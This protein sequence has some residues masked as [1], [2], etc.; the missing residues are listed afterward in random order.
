MP[1][2]NRATKLSLPASSSMGSPGHTSAFQQLTE[3]RA[4]GTQPRL[5][6]LLHMGVLSLGMCSGEV[7]LSCALLAA[8]HKLAK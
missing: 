7:S 6:A 1:P 4:A 8:V 3:A 2:L 5:K